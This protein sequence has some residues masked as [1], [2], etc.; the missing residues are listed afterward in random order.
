MKKF[1]WATLTIVIIAIIAIGIWGYVKA[2]S[3]KQE[4]RELDQIAL[5]FMVLEEIE[6]K[7]VS[8]PLQSWKNLYN[9]TTVIKEQ[10]D[11]FD[12]IPSSLKDKM[13]E[14][15]SVKLADKYMEVQYLQ[16]L[17]NGERKFNLKDQQPKSKGQIEEV[18]KA[19]EA[20]RKEI[21]DNN[22]S[23]GPEY[24][25]KM[26]ELEKETDSFLNMCND[27]ISKTTYESPATQLGTAGM[28]KAL[29]SLKAEII[30]SLNDFVGLQNEIKREVSNLV[31]SNW[32]NP[33]T[34]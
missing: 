12:T 32:I 33:L 18:V 9:N 11:T 21:V 8:V 34:R 30:Q 16:L 3:V 31:S 26:K 19:I 24:N 28:D 1:L 4:G 22:L 23:L 2:Q 13:N 10:I 14:F 17:M 7:D 27:I 5:Q 20:T 29:D 6:P 15:F 25:E